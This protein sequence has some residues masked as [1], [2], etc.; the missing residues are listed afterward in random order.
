MSGT[1]WTRVLVI[2]T[3]LIWGIWMI[4]PTFLGE[5]TQAMLEAQAAAATSAADSSA[6]DEE[7]EAVEGPWWAG[8]LPEGRIN[9]GLDLQGGIDMTLQ[10]EVDEAVVSAVHRD[11]GPLKTLADDDGLCLMEV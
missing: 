9:L 7:A 8:L 6:E 4:I 3:A 1:W 5:S 10:V 2:L 11:V